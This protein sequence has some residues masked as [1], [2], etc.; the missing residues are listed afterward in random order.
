[1]HTVDQLV[2]GAKNEILFY[3]SAVVIRH[4]LNGP[5]S[6]CKRWVCLRGLLPK[7]F[8]SSTQ[9]YEI[10]TGGWPTEVLHVVKTRDVRKW[11]LNTCDK[12]VNLRAEVLFVG[13]YFVVTYIK[14]EST[15]K[16]YTRCYI[17]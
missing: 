8:G 13:R 11:E 15:I 14:C 17:Q 3:L 1:M 12:F 4:T 16:I 10:Q 9:L 7:I 5:I 6:D 2:K